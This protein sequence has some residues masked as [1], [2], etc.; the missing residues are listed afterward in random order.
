MMEYKKTSTPCECTSHECY[1]CS[2]GG[3]VEYTDSRGEGWDVV[4]PVC[5]A[6]RAIKGPAN[7]DCAVCHGEGVTWE[8]EVTK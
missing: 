8:I 2:V 3:Y 6:E 7:P 5:D 1:E 4:C